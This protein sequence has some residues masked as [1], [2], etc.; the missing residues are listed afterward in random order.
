MA[1]RE[2]FKQ[3]AALPL[4]LIVAP[5]PGQERRLGRV[6]TVTLTDTCGLVICT[7][8]FTRL[9][10]QGLLGSIWE[11]VLPHNEGTNLMPRHTLYL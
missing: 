9:R 6:A 11:Q 1:S 4:L 8:T 2:W 10:E 7:T 5:D 3:E